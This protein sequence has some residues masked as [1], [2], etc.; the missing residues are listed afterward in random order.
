MSAVATKD[1]LLSLINSADNASALMEVLET[2]IIPVLRH[3]EGFWIKLGYCYKAAEIADR[4][5]GAL[6]GF[7]NEGVHHARSKRLEAMKDT[8]R[9]IGDRYRILQHRHMN[10]VVEHCNA[11]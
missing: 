9:Q 6:D 1:H 7:I 3:T 4:S 5:Y 8:M 10:P 11:G 2:S